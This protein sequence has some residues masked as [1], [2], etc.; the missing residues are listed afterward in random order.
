VHTVLIHV[1]RHGERGTSRRETAIDAETVRIGRGA[2]C[3]LQL[4]DP[5]AL[6]LHATIHRRERGYWIEAAP[7]AA[8]QI[9]GRAVEIGTLHAGAR[10]R[11]GP[12]AITV[13]AVDE[14]ALRLAVEREVPPAAV[15]RASIATADLHPNTRRWAWLAVL[16]TL[17]LMLVVPLG[18]RYAPAP[19]GPAPMP[20]GEQA[21]GRQASQEGRAWRAHAQALWMTGPM[22]EA[23]K[24]IGNDCTTCHREAFVPH[25]AEAC[26]S[27]HAE[28]AAHAVTA[29]GPMPSVDGPACATCHREHDG[30][31]GL[32]LT[33]Q[34]ICA[35]CHGTTATPAS[36]FGTAHPPFRASLP[37]GDGTGVRRVALGGAEP[38]AEQANLR[39]P[40]A[41]HLAAA[42]VRS[43]V[44]GRKAL[45][46]A[47]CHRPDATGRQFEPV[48]FGGDCQSC[49][50]LAFDPRLPGRTLP[51]GDPDGLRRAMVDAYLVAA[52]RGEFSEPGVDAH[53]R[54]IAGAPAGGERAAHA[55]L[56]DWATGTADVALSGGLIRRQCAECHVVAAKAEG[57][58]TIAPVRLMRSFM[59]AAR[60]DHG[61][62][63]LEPCAT[64]HTVATST[65]ADDVMLPEIATCRTC[66]G[67]QTSASKVASTCT[68]CHDFHRTGHPPMSRAATAAAR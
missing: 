19:P 24:A 42:G 11:I 45:A 49:H 2:A 37:A 1:T 16:L 4:A 22:S 30:P 47:D 63:R 48:T 65:Q 51:H 28:S 61:R 3:E 34:R 52:L 57:G 18:A 20:P 5:A 8:L 33:D 50:T 35:G 29:S 64:C 68:D 13:E 59:P 26:L 10:L 53:A 67:G 15:E 17:L 9:D 44:D 32:V 39:F 21:S 31:A 66:H 25:T 60:F 62:H 12:F 14:D 6:L 23:H 7:G 36:D 56:M 54:R 40:H 58:V 43:P 38:P 41:T 27:C 55:A 46:C